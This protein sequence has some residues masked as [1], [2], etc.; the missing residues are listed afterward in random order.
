M[1]KSLSNNKD[2]ETNTSVFLEI[3][4]EKSCK[5][6]LFFREEINSL[7]LLF[8][9]LCQPLL[10]FVLL[11]YCSSKDHRITGSY[12]AE[13][14]DQRIIPRSYTAKCGGQRIKGSTA[15][16]GGDQRIKGAATAGGGSERIEGEAGRKFLA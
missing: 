14:G 11:C 12:A 4:I 10:F 2:F 15:A 1:R 9:H 13:G 5:A 16:A 6:L 3:R 8:R 7:P